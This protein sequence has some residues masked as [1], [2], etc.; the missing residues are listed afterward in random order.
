MGIRTL[1]LD[2]ASGT[3]PTIC[4]RPRPLSNHFPTG[5]SP[6][7]NCLA[8]A[9]LT[10]A[11]AGPL[12]AALKSLPSRNGIRIVSIQ[13]G[14]IFKTSESTSP[15]AAPLIDIGGHRAFP[16][17]QR[18]HGQRDRLHTR[19]GAQ[20][21]RHLVPEDRRLGAMGSGLQIE[22]AFGRKARGLIR[23]PV[24][25]RHEQSGHEMDHETEGDL[26][27]N[28][29]VHQAAPRMR[30]F[31]AFERARRLDCRGAQRRQP[32]RTE[33]SRQGPAPARSPAPASP[34]EAPGAPGRSAD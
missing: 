11:T 22:N 32:G 17:H 3:R 34:R 15:G 29:R 4:D 33:T 27:G 14:E 12:S 5:F 16:A 28:Q 26:R 7:K 31:A 23:Q 13:P 8:N 19:S 6:L 25:R 18:P 24:E 2:R 20:V 21:F 10:I 1:S 9:W 30:I